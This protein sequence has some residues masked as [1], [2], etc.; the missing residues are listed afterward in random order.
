MTNALF[1]RFSRI[2]NGTVEDSSDE[3]Y[4]LYHAYKALLL[5]LICRHLKGKTYKV[6]VCPCDGKTSVFRN[7]VNDAEKIGNPKIVYSAYPDV[8]WEHYFD[9]DYEAEFG[10]SAEDLCI[11][12]N[13]PF[14]KLGQNM[15]NI[16]CDFLVFGSN[17]TSIPQG[18]FAKETKG[19]VYIK[20]TQDFNGNA[21]EFKDKYGSVNTFFYSNRK[22]LTFGR[23]YINNEK[24]K[25]SVMFGKDKLCLIGGC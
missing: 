17:A 7:L 11:F 6:I 25:T 12:T 15:E 13:P 3:Y 1:A 23:Q 19:F 2:S 24:T 9:M 16:K 5:E 4:T 10:C 18:V 8:E 22:F 21:D 14:K 20:N